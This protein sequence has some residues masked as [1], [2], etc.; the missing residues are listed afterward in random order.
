MQ[1]MPHD[2]P[3]LDPDNEWRP[4]HVIIPRTGLLLDRSGVRRR[5]IMPGRYLV[6]HSRTFQRKL[7]RLVDR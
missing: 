6:R 1:P 7:Y 4:C 3:S 2:D 5:L